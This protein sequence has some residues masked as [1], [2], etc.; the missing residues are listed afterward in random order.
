MN[1]EKMEDFFKGIHV[2]TLT[3]EQGSQMVVAITETEISS[4]IAHLKSNEAPGP[5]GFPSECTR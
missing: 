2:P 1:G 5:D 4:A 3:S